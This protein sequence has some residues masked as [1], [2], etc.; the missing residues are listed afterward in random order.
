MA[1]FYSQ[2]GVAPSMGDSPEQVDYERRLAQ[3]MLAENLST[4]PLQHPLQVLGKIAG[5]GVGSMWGDQARQSETA[6]RAAASKALVDAL[7]SKGDPSAAIASGLQTG[8]GPQM[9]GPVAGSILSNRIQ[10]NSPAAQTQLALQR[11]HLQQQQQL[12]PMTLESQRLA[13][14]AAREKTPLEI[15]EL[16]A[17]IEHG[18]R[19]Q[20]MDEAMNGLIFGTTPPPAGGSPA[21]APPA[22]VQPQVQPQS[23]PAA[24]PV[25]PGMQPVVDQTEPPGNPNIIQTQAATQSAPVSIP[26]QAAQPSVRD[27]LASRSPAERAAFVL[28]Y[29][30][31]KTKAAQMLQEWS[32]PQHLDKAS[33]N[34]LDKE[35]IGHTN[36]L[37]VLNDVSRQF[38]PKFLRGM[39]KIGYDINSAR[40][41]WAPGKFLPT[42]EEAADLGKYQSFRATAMNNLNTRLKE[43]SGTAVT[44][45]EMER[46]LRE[47]PNPGTGALSGDDPV[48]FKA[49]LDNSIRLAKMAIARF[50]YVRRQGFTGSL[51]E[52]QKEFGKVSLDA[53]PKVIQQRGDQIQ[54][55]IE[56]SNPGA[57]PDVIKASVKEALGREFGIGV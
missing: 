38:D 9:L 33:K 41:K 19:Q 1:N 40:M 31:D 8:Y 10:Q 11:L 39:D 57:N 20:A 24:P 27:I 45:T 7:T 12:G 2:S 46:I 44:A 17:K 54:K 36:M 26:A 6:G 29:Q 35:E 53:M 22:G 30:K 28:N 37:S 56:Q 48:T 25:S 14:D 47:L 16:R 50:R 5:A 34:M 13:L 23:A 55:L 3:K 15:Q 52:M 4:A 21:P 42:P 49:K 51:E 43:L 32:N 18:K